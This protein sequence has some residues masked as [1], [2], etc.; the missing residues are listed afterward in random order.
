MR[1]LITALLLLVAGQGAAQERFHSGGMTFSVGPDPAFVVRRDIPAQWES[2]APGAAGAPWRFW[3]SDMQVDRRGGQHLAWYDTAY[4][5][6]APSLLGDAGKLE[7]TF[8]PAYQALTIHRIQVRRDSVW[9]DRL[10]PASITL[11]RR[12]RGFERDTTDGQAAALIVLKDIRVGDVVRASY[13]VDGSNPI[14]AGQ[15]TEWSRMD[16]TTPVLDA[17]L[18]VLDDPGVALRAYR[19]NAAPEAVQRT[20]PDRVEVVA[21]AHGAAAVVDEGD[22]PPSHQ[23]FALVAVAAS[24]TWGDVVRWGRALYPA[25]EGPLPPDLEARI[26]EWAALPDG[27]ARL[28]AALR[29]VQDQVRYFGVEIGTSS[30]RPSPPAAT[31][32]RRY[33][34]CKD[35]AYLLTVLLQRLG[36]DAAPALASVGRGDAVARM[37]P[38]ASVFDHVI[39]RARLDGKDAWLDPT[40]TQQGGDPRDFDLSDYGAA[41]V[42]AP[43]V[44]ALQPIPP[45]SPA[46]VPGISATETFS[47]GPE[48]RDT[49]LVV[50]TTYTGWAADMQRRKFANSPVEDISRNYAEFYRKRY[51]EL[52]VSAPPVVVDDRRSNTLEVTERYV[53]ADPFKAGPGSARTLEVLGESLRAASAPPRTIARKGPLRTGSAPARFH[54]EIVV[55]LPGGWQATGSALHERHSSRAFDYANDTAVE[56]GVLKSAFDL[57]IKERALSGA[58]LPSHVAELL[59]VQNGLVL[60]LQMTAPASLERSDRQ[61][62]LQELI[63]G[64]TSEGR[65]P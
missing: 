29:A 61:R 49:T 22:Y 58:D 51:G 8:S 2:G 43:G 46:T 41:L 27:A 9:L 10:D 13:S 15:L 38:S 32:E 34:D 33:G 14:L 55:R 52:A 24:Q 26:A 18:R 42:L 39:V 12:E 17:W 54:H 21:H 5:A 56:G 16:W 57:T 4:E 20:S 28:A 53:L 60:K 30:H 11:V 50:A 44:A 62:R 7:L 19:E 40:I 63:R 59:K 45:A 47:A 25:V 35:K 3:L 64:L 48:G 65:Q 1:A 31:W 23:P 37:L 36:I 6:T